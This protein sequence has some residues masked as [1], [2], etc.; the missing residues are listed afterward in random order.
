MKQYLHSTTLCIWLVVV[1]FAQTGCDRESEFKNPASLSFAMEMDK[2]LNLS[3]FS[4]LYLDSATLVLNNFSITGDRANANNFEF[5]RNFVGG[6][7]LDLTKGDLLQELKFDMPQG[8]YQKIT[9]KF[10]ISA[11]EILGRYFYTNAHIKQSL[12]HFQLEKP[13]TFEI[14]M[15][16]VLGS[17]VLNLYEY[18]AQHPKVI[19]SPKSWFG[20]FTEPILENANLVFVGNDQVIKINHKDNTF[21]FNLIEQYMATNTVCYLY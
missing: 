13:K 4:N 19:F 7:R 17:S 6:L 8:T 9:I 5:T 10:E 18:I 2:G 16:D 1:L 15:R 20:N 14:E 11:L 3:S 21:I 12:V